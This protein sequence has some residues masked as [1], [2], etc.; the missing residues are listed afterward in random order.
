[1]RILY[2][3]CCIFGSLDLN[4]IMKTL[5]L[6]TLALLT[7]LCAHAQIS[8]TDFV[9]TWNTGN[10]GVSATDQIKIPANGQYTVYYESIPAGT[11]G[12]LP[13]TGLFTNTN[14][15]TLPASGTYRIAIKPA[16]TTPFNRIVFASEGDCEKL[17]SI[18]QWGTTIWWTFASS[19]AG[20]T[21]LVAIS[22]SDTPILTNVVQLDYAFKNCRSLASAPNI[23][24]WDV[25][26]VRSM[27]GTFIGARAF[28][29]PIGSWNVSNVEEMMHLFLNASSFNQPIGDW[30]VSA[31][32][33]MTGMFGGASAF[34]QPIGNWDVSA[35][36]D[37][38]YMFNAATAFN[39]PI[40][41]WHLTSVTEMYGMFSDASSFNQPIG[42][43]NFPK[44]TDL[45]FMFYEASSFNQ[46]LNNW[47]V[48]GVTTMKSMFQNARAFNQPISDWDVSSVTSMDAMFRDATAFNQDLGNW[49]LN[50]ELWIGIMLGFS[51]MDCDTYSKTLMGWAANPATPSNLT[52]NAQTMTYG[53]A[54]QAARQKLVNKGWHITN[55]SLDVNCTVLP[56]TL[57]SFSAKPLPGNIVELQWKTAQE[58]QNERFVVER[59]KDLSVFETAAEIRDVAG[60]SNAIHSYRATDLS[61]YLGTSYYR[62]VQYDVDGTR[63]ASRILSV[64]LRSQDY[65][66]Y[67]N[68][69]KN[70]CFQIS[71]DEPM[72]A[73]I[74]IYNASGNSIALGRTQH[75]AQTVTITPS[76][77][78]LSGTYLI[79]VQER[80]TMRTYNLF[81][82]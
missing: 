58:T 22:A 57:I 47:D 48:S 11:S 3:T 40:G 70:Q 30:D 59:S 1:M 44:V 53:P 36:T 7:G 67:P 42:T 9:T 66:L 62:L 68:P 82:Q 12:T 28:N 75:D 54:A 41:N 33:T 74:Q 17:V 50:P 56:V 49:K 69:L 65:S 23:G 78:L 19:F 21:N 10:Q 45:N 63:T 38:R 8:D 14:T 55:D 15:I 51:G 13:T 24:K 77:P 52:M 20:C 46:P 26:G 60:N 25:S 32:T 43:W 81:V 35:V 27:L 37:M 4:V 29:E 5:L 79:T 72:T 61:P 73:Q 76:E 34:N 16:G 6:F 80:A 31:V 18:E 71:V 39:Q 2:P 64:L